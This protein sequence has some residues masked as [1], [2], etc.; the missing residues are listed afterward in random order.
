[1]FSFDREQGT[2]RQLLN[3]CLL[4]LDSKRFPEVNNLTNR[5]HLITRL[6][7]PK[8]FVS[9][10]RHY[11]VILKQ[12]KVALVSECWPRWGEEERGTG[13]QVRGWGEEGN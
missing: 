8:A 4:L 2:V 12:E 5:N 6:H 11:S 9:D 13:G 1:M 10:R 7:K 3:N